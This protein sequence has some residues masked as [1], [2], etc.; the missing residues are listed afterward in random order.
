MTTT[1]LASPDV[2]SSARLEQAQ[3]RL[4]RINQERQRRVYWNDPVRWASE[5]LKVY[6]WS[7]QREILQALVTH[8][9]VAVQSCHEMG[10]SFVASVAAGWWLERT[11]NI[12]DHFVVS[13]APTNAQVALV[14][15]REIGRMHDRARLRGRVNQTAWMMERKNGT[16]EVV[17]VGRKPDDYNPSAFQGLHAKYFLAILDEAG[18]IA[19][20]I[21]HSMMS[22]CANENS[23]M[24]AIGNPDDP[25][26]EFQVICKPGSGW[27]VIRVSVFDTPNFTGEKVP[28]E[29]NDNLVSPV[30][31]EDMQRR[32]STTSPIYLSK[33]L[34]EFPTELDD[35][36]LRIAHVRAAQSRELAPGWPV[37]LGVDVA[38]EGHDRSVIAVRRG[39]VVRIKSCFHEP[40]T[41]VT[42]GKVMDAIRE[43]GATV[44]R[45]DKNGIGHGV[46]TRLKELH[47]P[48]E[49]GKPNPITIVGV[50]VGEGANDKERFANLKAEIYWGLRERLEKGDIDLE[51]DDDET[52]HEL[53]SLRYTLN[54][55]GQIVMESKADLK[56][57]LNASPDR[58]DALILAFAS[59]AD[60]EEFNYAVAGMTSAATW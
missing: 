58:A 48:S 31:V 49:D 56:K 35:G 11:V 47:P 37:E 12:G 55:R 1:S 36:L 54:S 28:K 42:T 20:Q 51:S 16:E 14:L 2:L 39:P 6:L 33:V 17:G 60:D 8:R 46:Y 25:T 38:G 7:K 44:V 26:A 32:F 23:R 15:W 9:K 43:T 52:I 24:L 18:G 29:L 50:N 4:Q 10:K 34:G 13:S 45:V 5:R 22:L 40:D 41:M 30:Y 59:V 27:H 21:V 57:R 53:L 3:L 19:A